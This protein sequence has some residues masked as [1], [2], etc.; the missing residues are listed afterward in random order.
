MCARP[1]NCVS[2]SSAS[3]T[4][5]FDDITAHRP[6]GVQLVQLVQ[7]WKGGVQEVSSFRGAV[8][9]GVGAARINLVPDE[10]CEERGCSR[11]EVTLPRGRG[12]GGE[13]GRYALGASGC[14]VW[15]CVAFRT[16]WGP[17]ARRWGE[18]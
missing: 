12:A 13:A 17:G 7:L 18:R 10:G 15:F 6:P 1:F 2:L 5:P 8:L 14:C 16:P 4:L 3:Q 9:S 11:E